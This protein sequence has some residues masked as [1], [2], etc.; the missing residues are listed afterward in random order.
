MFEIEK[1][2][3]AKETWWH[4]MKRRIFATPILSVTKKGYYTLAWHWKD[5]TCE[6]VKYGF[7]KP[8]DIVDLPA[9]CKVIHE[10]QQQGNRITNVLS[11]LV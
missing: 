7:S 1:I 9:R 2:Q 5:G 10:T 3:L 4:K 6:I 11:T 8:D